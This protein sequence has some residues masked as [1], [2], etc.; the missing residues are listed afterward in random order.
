MQLATVSREVSSFGVMQTARATIAAS[1]QVFNLFEN[2]YSDRFKAVVRELT[3]NAIDAQRTSGNPG[4]VQVFLPDAFDPYFRVKDTGIGMSH[5]FCMTNFMQYSNGSTKSQNNEAIG[6]FGIGSKSPF[7]Y[8]DQFTLRSV[9]NGTCSVYSIYKDEEGFP[10]IALMEQTSTD[11]VNGVEFSVPV[12]PGDFEKFR[13]AAI[14][15]LAYFG[16]EVQLLG[17]AVDPLDYV[18]QDPNG[19]WGIRHRTPTSTLLQVVMGGMAYPVDRYQLNNPHYSDPLT[20]IPLDLTLFIGSCSIAPSREALLYDDKTK[21][22][23]CDAIDAIRDEVTANMPTMFDGITSAFEASAALYNHLG[24]ELNNAWARLVLANVLHNGAKL[25]PYISITPR[26][27]WFIGPRGESRRRGYAS[28]KCPSPSW[29]ETSFRVQPGTLAKIIID[30]LPP[31]KSP[32]KRIKIF[33]DED[34]NINDQILVVR[35]V[36]PD[37]NRLGNPPA[38]LVIRTSELPEIPKAVRSPKSSSWVRPRVRMFQVVARAIDQRTT[39]VA[40]KQHSSPVR[41]IDYHNQP[42]TGILVVM[43][44]FELPEGFYQK[45]VGADLIDLSEVYLVNKADAPKLAKTWDS[46]DTVFNQRLAEAMV[47]YPNAGEWRYLQASPLRDLIRF[48]DGNPAMFDSVPK[49]TPMA[50][51]IGVIK[52]Y[53]SDTPHGLVQYATPKA[54]PRFDAQQLLD[55]INK[56]HW[57]FQTA[58][59]AIGR[60]YYES[61]GNSFKLLKELI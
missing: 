2:H 15:H 21:Q 35:G 19:M 54:P 39:R 29:S 47:E 23:I 24:G 37:L 26:A 38:D 42:S 31:H 8:T 33:V 20:Q 50:R 7:A 9:H 16:D 57:K 34:C 12:E 55:R 46:L 22:A 59:D 32:T 43:D 25:E 14:K 27:H 56:D 6:G 5:E 45:T 28:S 4:K 30:D 52:T 1:S 48:V 10:C 53:R 18:Q 40:P 60:T 61:N 41:E 13:N 3:A 58:R 36:D 51:L 44:N 49:H 11:E 17:A